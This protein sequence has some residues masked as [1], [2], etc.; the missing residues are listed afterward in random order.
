MLTQTDSYKNFVFPA[1]TVFFAS[2][3][4]I[5]H[6]ENEY[7]EPDTFNPDRWLSNKFGTKERN[8]PMSGGGSEQ[9]KITYSFGV[10]RRICS[11]QNFSE[12][13][14]RI[15][16]AKIVWAFDINKVDGTESEEIDTSPLSAYQGGFLIAPN[17]FP[18]KI[19]VRSGERG[20]VLKN[21]FRDLRQFFDEFDVV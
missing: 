5:H 17:K 2:T 8:N 7:S 10:G 9:R 18:G 20:E 15:M 12:N 6:D 21:E 13:S 11:G 16:M 19:T 1:G 3:W 14:M 4:A